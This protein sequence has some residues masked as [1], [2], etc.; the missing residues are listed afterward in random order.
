MIFSVTLILV[1][2]IATL[3]LW[4]MQK[5]QAV[6][7]MLLMEHGLCYLRQVCKILEHL[8]QHRGMASAFLNGDQGFK[9]KMLAMQGHIGADIEAIDQCMLGHPLPR[10][11]TLRWEKIKR[12]WSS[13]QEEVSNISPNDSFERHTA[14]ITE[15]LNLISDCA[16][17]MRISA[18]PDPDLQN[19]ARTTFNLLPTMIEVTGQARGIGTGAAAQGKVLTP[20]RIKLQFLHHRLSDTLTVSRQSIDACLN[21]AAMDSRIE[22]GTISQGF[23]DTQAFLDTIAQNM[24]STGT[25]QISAEEYF[26]RG[27]RAFDSNIRLFNAIGKVLDSDLQQRIPRL[28]SGL[29][30]SGGATTILAMLLLLAWMQLIAA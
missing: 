6:E 24:L 17:D 30:W 26:A 11:L 27:S 23:S 14:L 19:M 8:P 18:H 29:K 13:L 4:V 5:R 2:I 25:T 3:C 1:L 10:T 7:H 9:A 28:K 20:V 16:D 22:S 15:V 12:S 21:S